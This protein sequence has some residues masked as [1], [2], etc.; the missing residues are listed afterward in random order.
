MTQSGDAPHAASRRPGWWS[1]AKR[2]RWLLL[3]GAPGILVILAFHYIPL[4]GNI[5]A[6]KD[7]QPY[8]GI[9]DSAWNGVSNFS[10]IFNGDAD[11]LN[12]LKNTLIITTLQVIFVFPVPICLAL[13]LNSLL[14]ERMKRVVQS[15]LYLPHFMSWVI[16]VAIFQQMLGNAGLI[17]NWLLRHGHS[18]IHLIGN[19]SV[20]KELITAQV[21]WKD[22]GWGT[23]LFL[24]A[25]SQIDIQLY[26]ASG[27]DGAS[28]WRQ[29]WHVTLPGIRPVIILVLILRLGDILTVGFEQIVLQQ[30][31][32]GTQ[33]SE[34]LDTYVY[35]NGILA[36]NWGTSAAVGLVKGV[37][38]V[39]LV[40]GAN[41]LAHIF[42]ERGIY[43]S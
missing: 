10:V 23:I 39:V 9:R 42:G 3:F 41:K 43:Q 17:S 22:S 15:I 33:A 34:V 36:G 19:S 1:R 38:G 35:N 31:A 8:L 27:V 32:V 7:Y 18:G 37:L 28:R 30:P 21:I 13:L 24:A 5:I 4:L 20:F 40:L 25:L 12:A 26:E 11:F 29:L 6:F 2:D 16:V 14:S